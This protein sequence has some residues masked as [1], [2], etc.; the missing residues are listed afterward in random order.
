[1]S[2]LE[3]SSSLNT[4]IGC[5]IEEN[6]NLPIVEVLDEVNQ[7]LLE[8]DLVVVKAPPGAGKTTLLPLSVLRY[9]GNHNE[10]HTDSQQGQ[11]II[12]LEPRR[13]AAKTAAQRNTDCL[14]NERTDHG[15][16]GHRARA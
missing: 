10:S 9:L 8:V 16:L 5:V 13:M 1:M 14:R 4:S 12:V 7:A 15:K 2:K 3:S 11:K 6:R